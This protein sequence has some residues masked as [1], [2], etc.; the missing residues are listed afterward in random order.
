MSEW[1]EKRLGEVAPF[2]YG[3][4]LLEAN[5]QAGCFNVYSS[6]GICGRSDKSI[7][8][9]GIIVGR[10]GTVGSVFYSAFPFF[11]IDTA[12]YVDEISK[13]CDMKFLFYYMQLLKLE[14]FNNDAA[15]P[16]LNRNLAHKLRINI[17]A[18]PSVQTR[19]AKI[20]STY[21]DAIE[22][23]NHR[24]ALLEKAAQELYKE[25]FVRFRF[26][27]H[28][29]AKFEGGLPEG[30]EA[31]PFGKLVNIIDGD[32]GKNYPH[33]TEF[34]IEGYCLFLNAGNVT[35]NGFDFSD[36][37]FITEAKDKL[38]RK[39]KLIRNDMVVTTRGTVG[40]IAFYNEYVQYNVMRINSGMVILR[41]SGEVPIEFL[42]L[43]LRSDSI[44]QM[45]QL[46]SSGS[47]QPQLPIK[48]MKKMKILKPPTSIVKEFSSIVSDT[49]HE[50]ALL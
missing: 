50:T 2:K 21:D 10:K 30:W 41:D 1:V 22:N 35:K 32:R 48:D 45:I 36:N 16:G 42:Y 31:T 38:L 8:S 6:A 33:Q 9:K 27:G 5:R 26:P 49:L 23:N 14:S 13:N 18:E 19:I 47:A 17:P 25:W 43:T 20:L 37:A 15:V 24:I 11:C 4:S 29:N 44:Q 3:K 7:A 40:N 12:F 34:S 28:E 39:G 46:F